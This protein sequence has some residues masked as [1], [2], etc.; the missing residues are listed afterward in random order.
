MAGSS[1]SPAAQTVGMVRFRIITTARSSD[2]KR[3][4]IRIPP[5]PDTAA[6]RVRRFN[7]RVRNRTLFYQHNMPV[8]VFLSVILERLF[9]F[10][11][12]FYVLM[13]SILQKPSPRVKLFLAL[14]RIFFGSFVSLIFSSNLYHFSAD[15]DKSPQFFL[16]YGIFVRKL[17]TLF[18]PAQ[19]FSFPSFSP[20]SSHFSFF[21]NFF[22]ITVFSL[23]FPNF[24]RQFSVRH[25]QHAAIIRLSTSDFAQSFP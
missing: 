11:R 12:H 6:H 24:V 19:P 20:F 17:R 8:Q 22:G 25:K 7:P 10:R 9:L 23:H 13:V 3:F 14:F 4:L 5:F 1:S 16:F 2:R 18:F 21:R 15:T